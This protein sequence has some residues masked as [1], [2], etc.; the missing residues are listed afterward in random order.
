MKKLFAI[1]LSC[2]FFLNITSAQAM[3]AIGKVSSLTGTLTRISDETNTILK[4]GDEIYKLDRLEVAEASL[5]KI[6]FIDE[7]SITLG[8]NSALD[9]D[10]YVYTPEDSTNNKAEFQITRG[11]FHYISGL[12]SKKE[13]PDTTIKLDFGSIGI[14]GTEIWRDMKPD[15]EGNMT[16]RI[17][18]EDGNVTVFNKYGR[19]SLGHGEATKIYGASNPPESAKIWSKEEIKEIK[20]ASTLP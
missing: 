15:S 7:T 8:E 13:N 5:A 17:Y 4:A 6:S 2:A 18:I 10:E 12:V 3:E 11:A 9:I 16:C 19:T 14:R 20:S 1:L